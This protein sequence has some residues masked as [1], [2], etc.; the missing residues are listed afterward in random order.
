MDTLVLF[1]NL[2]DVCQRTS[3]VGAPSCDKLPSDW[4]IGFIGLF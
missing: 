2:S 4:L 1:Y 3:L